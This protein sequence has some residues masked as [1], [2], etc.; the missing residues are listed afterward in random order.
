MGMP[1]Q[2]VRDESICEE[3]NARGTETVV[4][5]ARDAGVQRF[6]H[7]STIDVFDAPPGG[8]FDE[9]Q[10]A[11]QPKNTDYERSKQHAEQWALAARGP[12]MELVFTNPSAVY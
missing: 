6:V 12:E 7:T 5:A 9:T 1:E 2:W 10:L 4:R 11:T 3:L 8:R